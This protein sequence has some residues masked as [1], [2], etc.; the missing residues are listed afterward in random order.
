MT[1]SRGELSFTPLPGIPEIGVEDDLTG[2][3]L[4]ALQRQDLILQDRDVLVVASKIV[5]KNQGRVVDYSQMEPGRKA[6]ALARI[7]D[8]DAGELEIMLQEG[9]R[10][11]GAIPV[12]DK[13]ASL[14]SRYFGQAPAAA[15]DALERMPSLLFF[16]RED[17]SVNSEAGIDESN[18]PGENT[19]SLLPQSPHQTAANL[20]AR[21]QGKTEAEI[22][23]IIN[24]SE[25]NVL[26]PG[27]S[28][29][30]LGWWG[31]RQVSPHFGRKDRQGL[32]KFGGVDNIVD[33]LAATC[34]LLMGQTDQSLPAVLVRGLPAFCFDFYRE[35]RSI[36]KLSADQLPAT[37]LLISA[38]FQLWWSRI[39]WR[40][41]L[42][43]P[44]FS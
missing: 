38:L 22:G 4:K 7:V 34:G 6:R 12:K 44:F 15:E 29:I 5:A 32:A 14:A 19:I 18:V 25:I 35:S 3:I 16:Q 8:R 13:Y 40:L 30:A 21:L 39:K 33:T 17:G 36:Q 31:L 26:R 43:N 11:L 42:L 24:D 20:A 1:A 27:S 2:E 10:F 9:G 23:V 28:D 41:L 37:G